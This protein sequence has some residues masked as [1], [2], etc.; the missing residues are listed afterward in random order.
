M[1]VFFAQE[2]YLNTSHLALSLSDCKGVHFE[3]FHDRL[4][5]FVTSF[6]FC[7]LRQCS[8][9]AWRIMALSTCLAYFQDSA[10]APPC[11]S[12]R[13]LLRFTR[14]LSRYVEMRSQNANHGK[15]DLVLCRPAL[16]LGMR[17]IYTRGKGPLARCHI[18]KHA[19]ASVRTWLILFPALKAN[20]M[21]TW[22]D[23]CII[24]RLTRD[25]C[26][27]SI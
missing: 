21:M 14:R 5:A 12:K 22:D 1:F 7:N 11:W 24:L 9:L 13:S 3:P 2:A 8:M 27:H 23:W 26:S 18:K 20:A 19:K 10:T 6:I 17:I 15:C 16:A 4:P 25:P